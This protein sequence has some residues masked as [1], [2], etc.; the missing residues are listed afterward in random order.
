ME[1]MS[2]E[3]DADFVNKALKF[4]CRKLNDEKI[5]YYIG[6]AIGAY[7][8]AKLPL[9]RAHEDLDILIEEKDVGKLSDIFRDTDFEF[10]DNR[11]MST[12]ILNEQGYADGD[13][14]VFA[15]YKY[16]SFHIGFFLLCHD[17]DSYAI[18]DYFRENGIQ[19]KLERTL[20]I[21]FFEAQY[22]NGWVEYAGIKLK[23][24]RKETIYKNK[25]V[26]NR[27]KDLFDL[28]KLKPTIEN[29]KL[30]KLKGLSKYRKT[31]IVDL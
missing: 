3:I 26:M 25:L 2:E 24:V 31:A 4:V 8:D 14:E 30:E 21:R 13:H 23:T 28:E 19:K 15:K 12:K 27:E 7:I 22:N 9:Q 1:V 29:D 20:P 6:G 18:T 5:N 11:L 10:Y 16:N 17:D